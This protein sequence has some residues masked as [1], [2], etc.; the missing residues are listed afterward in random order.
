MSKQMLL[1]NVRFVVPDKFTFPFTK[2]SQCPDCCGPG[3]GIEEKIIPE[4]IWGL[5]ISP[6]CYVHDHSW[7]LAEPTW[8]GFHAANSMFLH[9]LIAI[10][11]AK[12]KRT[13]LK[14]LRLYRCVTYFD[15]VDSDIG[16]D[17]FWR[18]KS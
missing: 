7:S 18:L 17:I 10:V 6:A 4:T 1:E 9:N 5:R 15:A 13:F 3:N 16:A 8:E 14:H 2:F 12:S 11:Q